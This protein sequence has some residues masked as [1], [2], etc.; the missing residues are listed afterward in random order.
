MDGF[1]RED[2][3]E[4]L[5]TKRALG[6]LRGVRGTVY[7][8]PRDA[9][10]AAF[11]SNRRI[12]IP[13]SQR[14][15]Q[16]Y[17]G[18]S[19]EEF[20]EL[21]CRIRKLLRGRGMTAAEIKHEL[22]EERSV[23]AAI[24]LMCDYGLLIRGAPAGGWKSNVHT[25]HLFEEYMPGVDLAAIDEEKARERMVLSYL[26]AFGPAGE[27]D[28]AWW[29]GFS[30]GETRRILGKTGDTVCRVGIGGV[31]HDL[32]VLASEV[33]ALRA[34]R[35]FEKSVINLLP[36]LDP[37]LM[38]YKERERYLDTG[39]YPFIYDR[40][41]NATSSILVDGRIIGVW[42][43][44]EEEPPELKVFFFERMSKASM[45]MIRR[46]AQRL[47]AFLGGAEA[48]L[49]ECGYMTPLADRTAGAFMTPLKDA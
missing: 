28:I 38:A 40:S 18:R 36:S 31:D 26:A 12:N 48:R 15:Y 4:E 41:G 16:R 33:A 6:K 5:Y 25:Y 27:G 9:L 17:T 45:C 46:E 20:D 37:Y 19:E 3:D 10:P 11:S 47:G 44:A 24:N 22:G 30:K 23:S 34:M 1:R 43:Y 42:D 32:F 29:T 13:N 49:K 35:P 21:S 39:N 14:F 7:I 8:Y 2:L